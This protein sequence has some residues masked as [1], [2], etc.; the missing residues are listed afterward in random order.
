[1]TGAEIDVLIKK[2]VDAAVGRLRQADVWRHAAP[3]VE[4]TFAAANVSTPILHGLGEIPTGYQL[5]YADTAVIASP[6]VQWDKTFAYLTALAAP[7][8]VRLVF[9]IAREVPRV[10]TP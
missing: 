1:M 3:C 7:A 6:G 10:V 9:G 4:F 8:H 5:L 2:A